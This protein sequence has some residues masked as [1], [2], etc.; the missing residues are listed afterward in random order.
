MEEQV[1]RTHT[2]EPGAIPEGFQHPNGAAPNNSAN[3]V[4]CGF[5]VLFSQGLMQSLTVSFRGVE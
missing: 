3:M 1:S 4:F 2:Q 5:C